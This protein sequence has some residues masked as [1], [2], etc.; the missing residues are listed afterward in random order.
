L[1]TLN[2]LSAAGFKLSI[3]DFGTGYSSLAYFKRLPVAELVTFAARWA[4]RDDA[5]AP[6][7]HLEAVL[8]S[9]L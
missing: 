2:T 9:R 5:A 6:A 7:R 4:G 1:A 3:D 8:H